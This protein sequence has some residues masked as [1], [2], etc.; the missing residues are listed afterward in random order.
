VPIPVDLRQPGARVSYEDRANPR[1]VGEIAGSLSTGAGLQYRVVWEDGEEA[2]VDLRQHGWSLVA[3]MPGSPFDGA[4]IISIYTRAQAI[5]DGFLV[6]VSEMAKEAGFRF[7]VAMTRAAW[8]D[9]VEWPS[10]GMAAYQDESGRLWDVLWM[11]KVTIA[12]AGGGSRI[13]FP[14]CRIPNEARATA[15]RERQLVAVCGPGD[16][17]EPVITLML[18]E[19]D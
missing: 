1:R 11:A 8:S 2:I 13:E 17:A 3:E 5:E 6:D 18:P 10:E 15:P 16:Q 7:P 14:I 4:D 9:C 19:E 12:R